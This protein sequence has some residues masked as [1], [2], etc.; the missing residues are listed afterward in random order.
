MHA[1]WNFRIKYFHDFTII[2]LLE[3]RFCSWNY[4]N[5]K[6][7]WG[8]DSDPHRTHDALQGLLLGR[9]GALVSTLALADVCSRILDSLQLSDMGHR[10]KIMYSVGILCLWATTYI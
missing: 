2:L 6:F 8:F 1:Q 10:L 5:F 3:S 4:T 9:F 7:G